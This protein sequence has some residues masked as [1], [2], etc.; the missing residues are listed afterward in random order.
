MAEH[1]M[2]F[3]R[4]DF[5]KGATVI[6]GGILVFGAEACGNNNPATSTVPPTTTV[7]LQKLPELKFQFSNT[8]TNPNIA[9]FLQGQLKQNLNIDLTLEPMESAAFQNLVNAKNHTWSFY[10]WGADYPDPENFLQTIYGT[11]QGNNKSGYSNATVDANIASAMKELD[12]TKRLALWDS[13]HKQVVDDCPAIYVFNRERFNLVAPTLKPTLKPTGQD[14]QIM[15]D[16]L[17]RNVSMPNGKLRL[18]LGGDCNTLDTNIASWASSL[19]ILFNIYDGLLGFDQNLNLVNVVAAEIPSIANGGISADG[20]TY[21]FKLK[22]NVTW[23]D[24]KPV[25]AS[26]F[27]Y[28][29][30]RMLAKDTAAE[31]A[32]MYFAIVGGE[33]YNA[34]TGSASGV[35]VTA[36]N[37]TTLEIKIV[38][39]QPTF[40]QVMALWP[41][42]PVR[43]DIIDA[44]GPTAA[45]QPPNLVSNG[46]FMLTE[47]V[48]LD[49]MTL[50]ANPNYWG[51]KPSLTEITYKQITDIQAS[52]AAYKNGELDMT[53][54]PAGTEK[55]TIADP[56][57]GSQIVRGADLTTYAFQ[58]NITKS[59]L[60]NKTLR[61]ALATAIDRDAYINNIRGGV[62]HATTSWIPPGMPGYDA[63]IG[64]AY[65]F[66][67]AKAK[68]LLTQA[69]YT[70]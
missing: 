60:T 62:G 39:A 4:R 5:V 57:Y 31:Y 17:L 45:F 64:A 63:T 28:S 70:P 43:K 7:P 54:V 66:D 69:G 21:T 18:N 35:G 58:F 34:G 32:S 3:T 68:Q 46:P 29:I 1:G 9:A 48:P 10:G 37:A 15:G 49:H 38:A 11:N 67:A 52:L 44:K 65:K 23:S 16:R 51:T 47:W 19:S 12:N 55:A 2:E 6:T 14:G 50:K 42:Y 22:S 27:E 59:P 13:V 8:G 30:K 41:V 36:L 40:P 20:K 25:T 24:G 53:G 61:Q 26:D 56:T 33:A